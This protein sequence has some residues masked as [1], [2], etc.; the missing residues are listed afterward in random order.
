MNGRLYRVGIGLSALFMASEASSCIYNF[1]FTAYHEKGSMLPILLALILDLF[2]LS[3]AV[4]GILAAGQHFLN[5]T[6]RRIAWIVVFCS[7]LAA[8]LRLANQELELP[9]GSR[10]EISIL[11]FLL[12]FL[13]LFSLVKQKAF[14]QVVR[15]A[16]AVETGLFIFGLFVIFQFAW[17]CLLARADRGTEVGWQDAAATV[18]RRADHPRVVWV[19]LD[20]LSYQQ[21]FEARD[22][23][24]LS[25]PTFDELRSHSVSFANV[26]PAENFTELAIPSM[27]YGQPIDKL[28]IGPSDS[29]SVRFESDHLWHPFD[30]KET[31]FQDVKDRGEN[32]AIV[33]WYNPYCRM[34]KEVVS[35]CYWLNDEPLEI[36]MSTSASIL[37]NASRFPVGWLSSRLFLGPSPAVANRVEVYQDLLRHSLEILGDGNQSLVVLHL[38]VPHPPGFYN[39]RNGAFSAKP[40]SYSDNL[41][42][43]DLT[44]KNL[45]DAIHQSSVAG[46][47]ILLVSSDHSWRP[48]VWRPRMNTWSAEDERISPR[49]FDPRIPLLVSFPAQREPFEVRGTF[50][51]MKI[52]N[53]IGALLSG[54]LSTPQQLKLWAETQ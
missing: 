14:D 51:A 5:N 24:G 29:V 27:F 50:P 52:R 49:Q 30:S 28:R 35:R 4:T 12:L 32:A 31:V 16:V 47:T 15:Y 53:L 6:L 45:S 42:L 3:L 13:I 23:N 41:A 1:R 39:R 7:A 34:L 37:Q 54:S 18:H 40:T 33:G 21:V 46:Q 20:E 9:L 25:L 43:A 17:T 11:V 36:G 19:L 2:V 22:Q 10:V 26:Q 44:L 38:P 48:Q 8:F